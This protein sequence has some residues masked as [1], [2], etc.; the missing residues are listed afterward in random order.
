MIKLA[1]KI[2]LVNNTRVADIPE[3]E[4]SGRTRR[5]LKLQTTVRARLSKHL[6][7]YGRIEFFWRDRSRADTGSSSWHKVDFAVR[8]L[9]FSLR[10]LAG[11]HGL[12]F[13]VGRQR[14]RDRFTWLMDSR[15]DAL[16]LRYRRKGLSLSFAVSK[17]LGQAVTN[18]DQLHAIGNVHLRVVPGLHATFF[19]IKE[20]D[21]RQGRDNPLW[22]AIQTHGKFSRFE[23]WAQAARYSSQRGE[24]AYRGYGVDS[25]VIIRLLSKRSGPFVSYHFAY[26][27][28]DD[29]ETET[30]RERFR[31]PQL[32]LNYYRHGGPKRSYYYGSLLT[33][34]LSNLRF[35]AFGLGYV[36]SQ[37]FSI[38]GTWRSYRQVNASE[39]IRSNS[40]GLSPEGL[41]SGLGNSAE[42]LLSWFLRKRLQLSLAGEWFFPGPAFASGTTPLF[43]LRSELLFYF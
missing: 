13:R 31:Q 26:G 17:K 30:V 41:D 16:Q 22:L 43:G 18:R 20:I 8:D 12:R 10:G 37:H 23:W 33:P 34:E 42:G 14:F 19:A 5:Y 7:G 1:G 9:Y 4:V 32:Q 3:E 40:L 39:T 25:G 28:A 36:F 15:L 11:V 24:I 38:Q 2:K 35:Q 21:Q 29:K 27:S 6:R